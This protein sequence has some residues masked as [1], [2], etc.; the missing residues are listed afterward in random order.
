[1]N[2]DDEADQSWARALPPYL[3]SGDYPEQEARLNAQARRSSLAVG[4][5]IGLGVILVV[6]MIFFEA[7]TLKIVDDI[8]VA[9][10]GYGISGAFLM[11]GI[12]FTFSQPIVPSWVLTIYLCGLVYGFPGG[13]IPAFIGSIVGAINAFLL[14][15]YAFSDRAR[16]FL[17]SK[18]ESFQLL[19]RAVDLEGLKLAVLIRIAP[20]PYGL[21]N[22]FLALTSMRFDHFLI[23]TLIGNFPK[24]TI[25]VWFASQFT[26]LK[27]LSKDKRTY[28]LIFICSAVV[29]LI[30]T[31]YYVKKRINAHLLIVRQTLSRE[32]VPLQR[33]EGE[34]TPAN[35]PTQ[36]ALKARV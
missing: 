4:L 29:L 2:Q 33:D 18:I 26:D 20:Y 14:T 25:H 36:I 10:R 9:V 27:S 16:T 22:S 15:R 30:V 11:T 21:T 6:V 7:K 31:M 13:L 34:A 17:E 28:S 19:N 24:I 1:M 23:A 35:I 8:G 32:V 3:E 12:T 5:V